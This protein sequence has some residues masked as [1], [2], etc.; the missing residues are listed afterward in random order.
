MTVRQDTT[1]PPGT[2]SQQMDGHVRDLRLIEE[3]DRQRQ[4]DSETEHVIPRT[5]PSG[6][7]LATPLE[8]GDFCTAFVALGGPWRA[9]SVDWLKA[10]DA[11]DDAVMA[12]Y[13]LQLGGLGCQ[14]PSWLENME[15]CGKEAA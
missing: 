5:S 7:N 15:L 1:C 9:A 8:D 14:E 12:R 11:P 10:C 13:V 2:K 4:I 3:L 6:P